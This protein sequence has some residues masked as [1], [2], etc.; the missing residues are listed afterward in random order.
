MLDLC[1]GTGCI[2]LL[3]HHELYAIRN[4]IDLRAVGIDISEKAL[5]LAAHNLN[6]VRK[7]KSWVAKGS[8]GY[9]KGDVLANPFREVRSD[10]IHV[11]TVL[12]YAGLPHLWDIVIS[13]PPYISPKA[14]WKTTTRSVRIFEPKLALVPPSQSSNGSMEQGDTFYMPIL[15]LASDVE[16]KIVLLE[17]ADLD[18]AIRIAHAAREMNAFDGIEIWRDQPDELQI[19]SPLV[20]GFSVLGQGNARSVVCWRGAGATWLAKNSQPRAADSSGLRCA[21]LVA[22][23]IIRLKWKHVR[24]M[25]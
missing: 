20:E 15:R 16:A 5:H 8:I 25:T 9:M 10:Q 11:S 1:T 18:Q 6:Q 21:P 14:Y 17:V 4:D 19:E 22:D 13:N 7:E 23:N 2:P 12:R 3:F 24:I